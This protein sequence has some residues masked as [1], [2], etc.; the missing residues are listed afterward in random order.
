MRATEEMRRM[1]S[2]GK[3]YSEI[4]A[5]VGVAKSTVQEAFAGAKRNHRAGIAAKPKP[6]APEAAPSRTLADFRRE[7]DQTWKIRDGL[8]RLFAGQ[9]I[10]TDAEF[11]EAV[12]GNPSRWRAAADQSEF[13]EHRY[14]V[15]GELLW[16]GKETIREMRKIRGEAI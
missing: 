10:M 13:K 7:H 16:A 15:G 6:T 12:S 4:A 1:R 5:A 9:V 2:E 14:R 8:R 3:S 11:R